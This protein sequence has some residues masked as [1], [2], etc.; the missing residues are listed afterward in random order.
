MRVVVKQLYRQGLSEQERTDAMNEIH[1]L[2]MM[3]HH[4]I[5]SYY[6][7]F[8]EE[9]S[10]D[11]HEGSDRE[12]NNHGR[13]GEIPKMDCF[14]IVMEYANGKH[15]ITDDTPLFMINSYIQRMMFIMLLTYYNST[16]DMYIVLSFCVLIRN[17]LTQQW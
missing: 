12:L 3:R 5:I 4:N 1:L 14:M 15:Q 17:V 9:Q 16:I 11:I 6:D 2:S 10:P 7:S 13:S 8:T